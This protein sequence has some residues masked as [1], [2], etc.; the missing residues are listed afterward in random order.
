MIKS[1]FNELIWWSAL[2]SLLGV[3]SIPYTMFL[4]WEHINAL[5]IMSVAEAYTECG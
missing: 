5:T 3:L 4:L 2:V 1:I